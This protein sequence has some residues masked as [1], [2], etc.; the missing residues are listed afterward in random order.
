MKIKRYIIGAIP[1][2]FLIGGIIWMSRIQQ[3]I[4]KHGYLDLNILYEEF[5]L[6]QFYDRELYNQFHGQEQKL[7][8]LQLTLTSYGK[9]ISSSKNISINEVNTFNRQ[10]EELTGNKERVLD[11]R[12]AQTHEYNEAI[13]KQLNQYVRDFGKENGYDF[14]HGNT[15]NGNL[16]YADTDAYDLTETVKKYINDRYNGL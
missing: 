13:W 10:I 9:R 12:E 15:G 2:L 1:V 7:D 3:N 8:S 5:E 11:E 16:M 14:I 4:P 6:T